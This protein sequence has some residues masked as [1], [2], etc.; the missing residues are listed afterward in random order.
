MCTGV[1]LKAVDGAIAYGRTME[2]GQDMQSQLLI[3]PR[4]YALLG[5]TDKGNGLQWK[6][7]YAVVGANALGLTEILD[8][9]NE[10]GLAGGLFYFP[11]YAR[12]QDISSSNQ[13]QS[14]APWQLMT[15]ILTTCTTV[16]DVK[17]ML[18]TLR[19]ANTVLKQWGVVPPI[20]AI[21][22]DATGKSV[23]IEYV[24]G[25][26]HVYDNPLGV[27]TN[28]P[29]FDWHMT[30]VRNYVSISAKNV[31]EITIDSISF[32]PFGQGSGMFGLPGDFTPPSR[33]I[34]A[35][36]YSKTVT[37]PKNADDARD[38][39]SHILNLFD[40]PKGA[41]CETT[42]GQKHCD[43]TQWTGISDLKNKRYY[44]RTYD[45]QTI[46]IIDLAK[47]NLDADKPVIVP[48]NTPYVIQDV[49]PG[50]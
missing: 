24:D 3:I 29:T 27:I 4:N 10:K 16:A 25:T 1:R 34:R 12:F 14:I 30:N 41:V 2:F 7:T 37:Q 47:C 6:S 5:T 32:A 35:V 9:V 28:S 21:V 23:V 33:F 15:W 50:K 18:P 49:T 20:H 44:M 39:V 36:A 13:A 46:R 48:I 45:N 19:V 38:C 26:L 40:I 42:D 8:G 31:Q 22:H 17:K 11:G 43:F